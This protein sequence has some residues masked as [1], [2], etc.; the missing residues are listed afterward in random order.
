MKK[1]AEVGEWLSTATRCSRFE[2]E[3]ARV[4]IDVPERSCD[5]PGGNRCRSG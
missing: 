3:R 4:R 5:S 1:S 2:H